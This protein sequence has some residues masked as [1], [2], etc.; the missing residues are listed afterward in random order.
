MT[1]QTTLLV[2]FEHA[3]AVVGTVMALLLGAVARVA[4]MAEQMLEHGV[5]LSCG[6]AEAATDARYVSIDIAKIYLK[7]PHFKI[8]LNN[9]FYY[10]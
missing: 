6:V 3:A 2:V 10:L 4:V 7:S 1:A 9:I 5:F 8:Y